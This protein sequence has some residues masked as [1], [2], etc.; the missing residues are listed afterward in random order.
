MNFS[1]KSDVGCLRTQNED[2]M[3][4]FFADNGDLMFFI[5]ADGMGGHNS[6]EIASLMTVEIFKQEAELFEKKFV[7]KQ[8]N[9]IKQIKN[10]TEATLIRANTEVFR[11]S[12]QSFE[13]TGMGTTAVSAIIYNGQ[14]VI[15]N[16]GDSRAYL[17]GAD[18]I[19]RLTIDHSIVQ[20]LIDNGRINEEEAMIHPE[21]NVITRAIGAAQN[22]EVD[23]YLYEYCEGDILILCSDGL[24]NMVDED[25]LFE[26]VNISDDTNQICDLLIDKAKKNGGP[27]NITVTVVKL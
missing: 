21:K 26:L 7:A 27:D 15:G 13:N 19:Q 11:K 18:S 3:G 4:H 12:F 25:T 23:I 17:I 24:N 9:A 10:F 8:E 20:N 16:I 1:E 2:C 14:I 22:I 5:V 6:G